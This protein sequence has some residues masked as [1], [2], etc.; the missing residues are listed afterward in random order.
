M[1]SLNSGRK[2]SSSFILKLFVVQMECAS[3]RNNA[4]FDFREK[5][6]VISMASVGVEMQFIAYENL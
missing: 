5:M 6:K 3:G 1:K 4:M 2:I